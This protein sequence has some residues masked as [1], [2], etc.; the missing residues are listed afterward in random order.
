M[1]KEALVWPVRS[2]GRQRQMSFHSL[3]LVT[4]S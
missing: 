1:L 4:V 3:A 2:M